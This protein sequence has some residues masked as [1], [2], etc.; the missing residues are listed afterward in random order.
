MPIGAKH[1]D[2]ITTTVG[3]NTITGYV[4]K[5]PSVEGRDNLASIVAVYDNDE[6]NPAQLK[7]VFSFTL[8]E[9]EKNDLVSMDTLTDIL[10]QM[11]KGISKG[12]LKIKISSVV[13][14]EFK[15][16]G[17]EKKGSE[18]DNIVSNVKNELWR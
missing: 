11:Y 7:K 12:Q 8:S 3:A 13:T 10:P 4:F 16:E 18:A 9:L 2:F 5:L 1:G 15:F 6:Y 14:L 17:D